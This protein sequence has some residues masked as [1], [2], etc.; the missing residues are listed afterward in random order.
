MTLVV[1]GISRLTINDLDRVISRIGEHIQRIRFVHDLE[2]L[3]VASIGDVLSDAGINTPVGNADIGLYAGIDSS[4]EDVKNEYFKGI[5]SEGLLGASPLFFP[6]TS[7]NSLIAQASIVFDIRGESITLPVKC[8][9]KD[10]VEYAV[11]CVRGRY[12]KMAIAGGISRDLSFTGHSQI[13]LYRAEFFFIEDLKNAV[14][15]KS[16]I[17]HSLSD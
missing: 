17:Y 16:K 5:L 13:P 2:K 14:E 8:L 7:P 4:I 1:T 12:T 15:R 9:F 6:F 3:T 11:D 10:V